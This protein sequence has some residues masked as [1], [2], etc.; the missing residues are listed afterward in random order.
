LYWIRLARRLKKLLSEGLPDD[1]ARL[2][3]VYRCALGRRPT[4]AEAEVALRFVKAAEAGVDYHALF[5]SV[6][7]RYV[8]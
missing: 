4:P 1:A 8:N 3:R 7:F 2:A 6:E 5:A